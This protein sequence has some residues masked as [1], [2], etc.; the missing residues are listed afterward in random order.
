MPLRADATALSLPE[1]ILSTVLAFNETNLIVFVN[2]VSLPRRVAPVISTNRFS[3]LY[4]VAFQR[5]EIPAVS[6]ARSTRRTRE[7]AV[8]ASFLSKKKLCVCKGRF[9]RTIA[10][11][12]EP[13]E[14]AT[15][16]AQLN[17]TKSE[18]RSRPSL[19]VTFGSTAASC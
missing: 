10:S 17:S 1:E 3:I 9:L 19:M 14:N 13:Y 11:R 15:R 18:I 16:E 8:S 2:Q 4:F 6:R 12:N 5:E 7:H